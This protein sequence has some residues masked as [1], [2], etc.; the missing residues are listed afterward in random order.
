MTVFWMM[1]HRSESV[2]VFWTVAIFFLLPFLVRTRRSSNALAHML[3]ANFWQCHFA[4]CLLFGG[5]HA[6][7]TAWF[8]GV[9]LVSV[10]VGGIRTGLLWGIVA[11]GTLLGLYGLDQWGLV[12]FETTLTAAEATFI[13]ATGTVGLLFAILG[14]ALAYEV[15]KNDSIDRRKRIEAELRNANAELT[16]IDR[17]KTSFFQNISHE[18]RTPLTLILSPLEEAIADPSERR[19]LPVA[20]RNARRLLRLVNQL[21]DFQKL[22]AEKMVFER[23]P[24]ELSQFLR[25][26]ADYFASACDTKNIA[27]SVTYPPGDDLWV[28]AEVDA[29]EKIV[30]NFLSNALKFTPGGG[31]I[32]L[33]LTVRADRVRMTVSDTGPG[34]PSG[35]LHTVFNVFTQ[36]DDSATRAYEG[37]GLGLALARSLAEELDGRVGVDSELGRGSRFW[38][39]LPRQATPTTPVAPS[40]FAVKDWLLEDGEDDIDLPPASSEADTVAAERQDRHILVVDDLHAMRQLVARTLHKEGYRV[41]TAATGREGLDAALDLRPDI[42]ITDWMMPDLTGPELVHALA[43]APEVAGTPVVLLTAKSDEESKLIGTSIG[44]SAFLGK[45]FNKHELLSTI[46]NLLSLKQREREVDALNRLLTESVLKRYL[47]PDLVDQLVDGGVS[48]DRP[49]LRTISVLFCDI[50][51]FTRNSEALGPEKIARVLNEFLTAMTGVV[52]QHGGTIDKFMGDAVMVLFGAPLEM[53]ASEQ[54]RRITDCAEAMQRA[55]SALADRFATMGWSA[56]QIRIGVHQGEAVVGNFGSD[57]RADYTAI[58]P[59]VNTTARIER[60]CRPGQVWM[61]DTVRQQILPNRSRELGSFPLKGVA[62]PMPLFQLV[63]TESG[64]TRDTP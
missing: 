42:V 48:L 23:K 13:K 38:V 28:H 24:I 27:F 8:V 47:P 44:A 40:D 11:A 49:E 21:L 18:L 16:Q 39:D 46:R 33:S 19:H 56:F 60:A 43:A 64:P 57:Q 1:G 54:A 22:R 59:V 45:P 63:A 14:T 17:Q 41:S 34:I 35:A 3:S 20:L 15:L 37:S 55:V 58:G 50:C 51:D 4:L 10:L 36:V 32:E 2:V 29:L 53:P 6:P 26:C 12:V 7:N 25:I 9:P 31:I 30:F 52:F 62:E 5:V 61:S